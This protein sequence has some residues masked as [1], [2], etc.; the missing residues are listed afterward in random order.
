VTSVF[1]IH[2]SPGLHS[3]PAAAR[4]PVS[5]LLDH[6]MTEAPYLSACLRFA[7]IKRVVIAIGDIDDRDAHHRI[8]RFQ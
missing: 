5:T 4:N 8:F 2:S 3:T 7:K 1:V 6:L